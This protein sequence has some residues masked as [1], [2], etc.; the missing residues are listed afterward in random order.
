MSP[1]ARAL[2]S[3]DACSVERCSGEF[4]DGNS[5]TVAE[6]C[7]RLGSKATWTRKNIFNTPGVMRIGKAWRIPRSALEARIRQLMSV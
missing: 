4:I 3:R 1:T 7:A 5:F 6:V 2:Q